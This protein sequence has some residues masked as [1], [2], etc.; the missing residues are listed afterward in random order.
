M[1]A[2]IA[3]AVAMLLALPELAFAQFV[4]PPATGLN[5]AS[6]NSW[7]AGA[8][9]GYNWQRGSVVY[10][11]EADISGTGLKNTLNTTLQS[12][13]LPPPTAI[14]TSSIDWYG[15]VRG[16]LGWGD[17]SGYGLRYWRSCLRQH[18]CEQHTH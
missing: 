1:R 5:S 12:F 15:T 2:K 3:A 18:Q 9:A 4:P 8:Q 11:L 13:F 14:T 7:L 17:G 16:R 10:G 6:S